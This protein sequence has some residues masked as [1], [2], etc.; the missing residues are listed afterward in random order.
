MSIAEAPTIDTETCQL[1][2]KAVEREFEGVCQR[3]EAAMCRSCNKQGNECA[4]CTDEAASSHA[5]HIAQA[6]WWGSLNDNERGDQ[7]ALAVR[8]A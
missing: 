8:L 7:I 6:A 1:C 5:Q 3:C 4:T 2:T